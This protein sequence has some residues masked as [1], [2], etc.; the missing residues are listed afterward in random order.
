MKQLIMSSIIFSLVLGGWGVS[1]P[2][3]PLPAPRG[4]LRIVDNNPANR[5]SL[6]F[7]IFEHLIEADVSGQLVPRLATSWRWLNDRTLEMTLRQGV[8]FHNG[9]VFDAEIV[10]LN[11]RLVGVQGE[12]CQARAGKEVRVVE[13][14]QRVVVSPFGV[15][16]TWTTFSNADGRSGF[17]R[18]QR[19]FYQQHPGGRPL[20][21][22]YTRKR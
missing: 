8:T 3:E 12:D 9:E 1:S 14:N 22:Q 5:V 17:N 18:D 15:V 21:I 19:A 10:S 6:T 11:S 16:G 4:E 13:R 20:L 7:N 2:G